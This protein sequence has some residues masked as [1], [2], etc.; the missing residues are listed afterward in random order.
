MATGRES[1]SSSGMQF[2]SSVVDYLEASGV[3][4]QRIKAP[5]RFKISDAISEDRPRGDIQGIEGWVV[6][7][8]ARPLTTV[9]EGNDE[10]RR[11]AEH[12]RVPHAATVWRRPGGRLADSL[13]VMSIS[14]FSD[15]I[16]RDLQRGDS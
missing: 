3:T 8:R 2:R 16:R 1:N 14:D 9:G 7:T 5:G 6:N 10:A 12:D 4:V 15:L 11:D 13:V